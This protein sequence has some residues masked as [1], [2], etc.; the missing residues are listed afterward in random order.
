[1]KFQN[2]TM[3]GSLDGMHQKVSRTDT[4][5]NGRTDALTHGQP[6]TNSSKLGA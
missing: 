5:T 6:E 4:Q 3:H 1:M 2:P